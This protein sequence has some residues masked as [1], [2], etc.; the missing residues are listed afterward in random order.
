MLGFALT[1]L[2]PEVGCERMVCCQDGPR[3]L[4]WRTIND[5]LKTKAASMKMG[6]S[7]VV[8]VIEAAGSAL[9][10][11]KFPPRGTGR[12]FERSSSTSFGDS[13]CER[14]EGLDQLSAMCSA[15]LDLGTKPGA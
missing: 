13:I 5:R 1:S 11:W 3:L 12:P 9:E 2:G 4:D 10:L 6:D 7:D 8:N 14:N 15:F